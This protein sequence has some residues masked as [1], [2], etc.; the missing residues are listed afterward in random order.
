MAM[1]AG[2]II[3]CTFHFLVSRAPQLGDGLLLGLLLWMALLPATAATALLH[4]RV[5]EPVEITVGVALTALYG[6]V[7][8]FLCGK[9]WVGMA[10]GAIAA[11][12]IL[13]KAGG[14]LT[15]FE[16]RRAVLIFSGLLPV[17]ILF[18]IALVAALRVMLRTQRRS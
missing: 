3:A 9:R 13:V 2:A 1:V 14:P 6:A 17:T 16:S 10:A 12:A 15:H 8:G 7:I 4:R 5:P 11:L 18:G